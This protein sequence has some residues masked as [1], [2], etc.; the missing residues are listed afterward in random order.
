VKQ[1]IKCSVLLSIENTK[2]Y[3]LKNYVYLCNSCCNLQKKEEAKKFRTENVSTSQTRSRQYLA[4]LKINN[5]RK[6]T[7]IQQRASALKR[8]QKFNLAFDLTTDYIQTLY[9]DICPVLG[10]EL[11]Y[12][13]GERSDSSPSLDRINPKEGYVMNNVQILSAKANMMKSNATEE[14]LIRFSNWVLKNVTEQ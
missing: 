2:E 3:R 7:A 4:N 6:Y 10:I 9:V 8:A 12:G 11:K 13:G 5:P 14:E 1:C